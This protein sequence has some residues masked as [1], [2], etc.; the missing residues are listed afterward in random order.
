MPL[1][2]MATP[3][4]RLQVRAVELSLFDIDSSADS[5]AAAAGGVSYQI[6]WLNGGSLSPTL[7]S[8]LPAG[9]FSQ[10][11]NVTVVVAVQD[12]FGAE[13]QATTS[14]QV[15]P[16]SPPANV[17]LNDAAGEL[18]H[19]AATSGN[20]EAVVNSLAVSL[21]NEPAEANFSSA[22]EAEAHTAEMLATR[23]IL[24]DA[25][26]A[27]A[28]NTT[29]TASVARAANVMASITSVPDQ[30]SANATNKALALVTSLVKGPPTSS[31]LLTM[32]ERSC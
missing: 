14:V 18:L 20:V 10:G 17:S 11:Y 9:L 27:T 16:Y 8:V 30:L 28:I 19:V 13:S 7:S 2:L 24:V 22:A 25:M 21:N 5:V 3:P 23:E 15:L 31:M 6:G 32:F 4:P 1:L 12:G 29:G 26:F